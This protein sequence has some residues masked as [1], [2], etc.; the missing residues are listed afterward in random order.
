MVGIL[1]NLFANRQ[2]QP[3]DDFDKTIVN[4][5][6]PYRMKDLCPAMREAPGANIE[7]M[8]E[9]QFKC[10]AASRRSA[11]R[12]FG[13]ALATLLRCASAVCRLPSA[14][15]IEPPSSSAGR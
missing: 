13:V 10:V 5:P 7:N 2:R 6:S 15:S 8:G 14:Y 11:Y 9:Q 3:A 1:K 12:L 4:I